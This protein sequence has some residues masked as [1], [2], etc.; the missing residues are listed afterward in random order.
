MNQRLKLEA[1]YL[2]TCQRVC[3]WRMRRRRA[4]LFSAMAVA[5]H[6]WN[7]F[8]YPGP[9]TYVLC[10]LQVI[11]GARWLAFTCA[12]LKTVRGWRSDASRILDAWDKDEQH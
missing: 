1:Y 6:S 2:W 4:L 8:Y 3:H 10:G 12:T 5:L 11:I 7:I 9:V